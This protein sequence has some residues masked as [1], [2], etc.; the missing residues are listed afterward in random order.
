MRGRPRHTG[1]LE[2]K[3]GSLGTAISWYALDLLVFLQ[4]LITPKINRS[5]FKKYLFL[6]SKKKLTENLEYQYIF[7]YSCF[8]TRQ[9][10]FE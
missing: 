9:V 5:F 7:K 3:A 2:G 10:A 6:S 4:C 1:T 8:S